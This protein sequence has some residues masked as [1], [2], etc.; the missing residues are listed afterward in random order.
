MLFLRWT[1]PSKIKCQSKW[2]VFFGCKKEDLLGLV[3]PLLLRLNAVEERV[4][5][6]DTLETSHKMKCGQGS[7]Y[8]MAWLHMG[9]LDQKGKKK[10]VVA[11]L[12]SPFL[13]WPKTL[14]SSKNTRSIKID[15]NNKKEASTLI[16]SERKGL[17]RAKNKGW[18]S[19]QIKLNFLH[20]FLGS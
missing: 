20:P 2:S 19:R 17:W 9:M 15:H 8:Q 3:L 4:S 5:I 12:E 13:F 18:S 10:K 6:M 1:Y 11:V 16:F 14:L 7:G